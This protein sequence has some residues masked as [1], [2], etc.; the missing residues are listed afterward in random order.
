LQHL[1]WLAGWAMMPSMTVRGTSAGL[2]TSSAPV[3][4]RPA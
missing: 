4:R 1:I 2:G 3:H